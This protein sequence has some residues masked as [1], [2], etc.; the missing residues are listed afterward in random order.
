MFTK[1][2]DGDLVNLKA[3]RQVI[4]RPEGDDYVVMGVFSAAESFTFYQG[5]EKE[6]LA[7]MKSCEAALYEAKL[8]I[9]IEV[10]D[11]GEAG[12]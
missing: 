4:M 1:D 8:L 7:Y 2:F 12:A 10:P 5:S 6:C 3:V 9:N 11:D